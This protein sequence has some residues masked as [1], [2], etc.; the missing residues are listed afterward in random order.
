MGVK[1]ARRCTIALE[2]EVVDHQRRVELALE[3]ID[4]ALSALLEAT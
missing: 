2:I 3:P 4:E 1:I